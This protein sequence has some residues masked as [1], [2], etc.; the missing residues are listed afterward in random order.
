[1]MSGVEETE[2]QRA[3]RIRDEEATG[4]EQVAN[5]PRERK[6]ELVI[7][8]LL[9]ASALLSAWCA[10]QSTRLGS[11]EALYNTRAGVLQ[12]QAFRAEERATLQSLSDL[13]AFE[14]WLSATYAGDTKRA[15][16]I[17]DRFSSR[18]STAFAAWIATNPLA[19]EDAPGSP[20]ETDKYVRPDDVAATK[21]E[22][23]AQRADEAAAEAGAAADKYVLA[24][25]LL[26]AALFLLGIQSRIGIFELRL[27]MTIVAS[28]LVVG[29]MAWV[30]T[31]PTSIDF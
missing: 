25:V 18:L 29:S 8:V 9:S 2:Q 19:D 16:F 12:L 5:S 22:Q 13:S 24:V 31:L 17:E 14:R 3:K 28:I 1:M 15:R 21:F 30:L 4:E 26:A 20:I 6:L 23:Q 7:T 10:Y 27:T 11:T